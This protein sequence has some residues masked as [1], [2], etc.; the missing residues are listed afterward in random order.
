MAKLFGDYLKEER[1]R[2]SLTVQKLAEVCGTSRSYI[3]LI[4]NG[5]RMPGKKLI[6][7]I[8]AALGLRTTVVLNWY[9]ED[10]NQKI[11]SSIEN[12]ELVK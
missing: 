5:R 7:Q 3:T 8:A 6:P 12:L 1:K 4:E 9:L 10:V 11:Q 2:Q